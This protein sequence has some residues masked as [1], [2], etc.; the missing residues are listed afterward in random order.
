MPP[1]LAHYREA[2]PS[3]DGSSVKPAAVSSS[4]AR[5]TMAQLRGQAQNDVDAETAATRI[6][7]P[8]DIDASACVELGDPSDHS[9]S[10]CSLN[11]TAWWSAFAF[12]PPPL[13]HARTPAD[14]IGELAMPQTN[15][16]NIE[17]KFGMFEGVVMRVILNIVG[18]MQ[19]MRISWMAGSAG[20]GW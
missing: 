13:F 11:H 16:E 14:L 2:P 7:V 18:V 19:Y 8:K 4:A 3:N 20:I 5:P 10:L 6:R 12:V 9:L 15:V 17:K 1:S